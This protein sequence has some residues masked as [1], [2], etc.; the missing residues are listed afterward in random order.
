MRDTDLELIDQD[1]RDPFDFSPTGYVKQLVAGYSK[2]ASDGSLR[3]YMPDL[4]KVE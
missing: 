2:N 4:D 1:P 3:V